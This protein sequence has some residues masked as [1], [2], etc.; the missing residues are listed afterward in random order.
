MQIPEPWVLSIDRTQWQFGG[1]IFNILTLGIVHEGIAFPVVYLLLDKRGN[2]NTDERIDLM[3]EFWS[4]FPQQRIAF[5]TADRE[6]V[7][8]V[9]LDYLLQRP[10]TPFRIRIRESELLS[11]GSKS[12]KASVLFADLQPN[13]LKVLAKRRRLWGRWVYVAATRLEDRS[14]AA[15]GHGPLTPKCNLRLRQKVGN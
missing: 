13:Q 1:S 15:A 10:K 14:K 12:L 2:S 8:K 3:Q 9:W 4:L 6:F 5:L 7:G 11:D